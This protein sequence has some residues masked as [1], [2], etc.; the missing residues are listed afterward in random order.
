MQQQQDNRLLDTALTYESYVQKQLESQADASALRYVFAP[1]EKMLILSPSG[2]PPLEAGRIHLIPHL[3]QALGFPYLLLFFKD[4]P[5]DAREVDYIPETQSG[6]IRIPPAPTVDNLIS[7]YGVQGAIQVQNLYNLPARTW[8]QLDLNGLLFEGKV[9]LK[10]EEYLE[11]FARVE[12]RVGTMKPTGANAELV[13]LVKRLVP[14]IL[15]ELVNSVSQAASWSRVQAEEANAAR[16]NGELKK[17]SLRERN[18]FRFS[19]VTP[20]DQALN[21]VAENQHAAISAL[22]ALM[23]KMV[24]QNQAPVIDWREVGRGMAEGLKEA[25][26]VVMPKPEEPKPEDSKPENKSGRPSRQS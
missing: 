6:E 11:Q 7:R 5:F 12:E 21:Q 20:H 14:D 8:K 4:R 22:P 26:L 25:G 19:G 15:E 9:F 23:E 18:L 13:E 1:F 10:P 24:T 2:V 17:F 16:A 3:P